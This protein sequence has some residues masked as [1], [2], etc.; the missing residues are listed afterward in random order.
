MNASALKCRDLKPGDIMLK[1]SDS[2]WNFSGATSRVIQFGQSLAGGKNPG[3]VHA[4][5]MFDSTYMIEAQSAGITAHDLRVQNKPYGY[6]VY[7]CNE[8][9]IAQGAGTCAKMMFDIHQRHGTMKYSVG[10]AV[11]SLF[12][13]GSGKAAS[14]GD[15]D[16]L[17]DR[18][19]TGRGNAFFCS[20]FVV[21]VY[22]FVA[23]QCG[24]NAATMFAYSD[25]KAT[26]SVLA[27]SL[28][29]RQ[30]FAEVGCIFPNER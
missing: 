28:V 4:G 24:R 21:Y 26:P 1:V 12:G 10:G 15:M 7:R 14:R 23:E 19:L 20:Q 2:S 25:A 29:K 22:Q 8:S 27:T 11:G 3:I 6:Y 5:L 16:D 17:L 9:N 30:N 13:F 18:V